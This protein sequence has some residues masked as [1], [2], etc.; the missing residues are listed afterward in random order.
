MK[1]LN[2]VLLC[3]ATIPALADSQPLLIELIGVS[4]DRFT[5]QAAVPAAVSIISYRVDGL[6]SI[7]AELSSGLSHQPAQAEAIVRQRLQALDHGVLHQRIEQATLGL[8]KAREY[9]LD[10]YPAIVFNQGEAV[11]YGLTDLRRAVEV[12]RRWREQKPE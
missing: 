6:A 12:Y 5:G 3:V 2:A 7:M 8:L 11:L 4:N 10:R 9:N 1:G